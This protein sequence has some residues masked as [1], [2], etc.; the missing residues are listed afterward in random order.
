MFGHTFYISPSPHRKR[1]RLQSPRSRTRTVMPKK[2]LVDFSGT[3]FSGCC[4]RGVVSGQNEIRIH[5]ISQMAPTAPSCKPGGLAPFPTSWVAFARRICFS[6][7]AIPPGSGRAAL[8]SQ[9]RRQM[10]AK[11]PLIPSP[12]TASRAFLAAF[13]T[14][15]SNR[16]VPGGREQR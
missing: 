9:A 11:L 1:N 12:A 3:C 8:L 6:S 2:D 14:A 7:L 16:P 13:A 15:T 4:W 10:L 5:K